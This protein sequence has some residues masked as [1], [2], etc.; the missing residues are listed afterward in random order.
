ALEARLVMR[1]PRLQG[2]PE[3]VDERLD[4]N[5]GIDRTISRPVSR[6]IEHASMGCKELHDRVE[7]FRFLRCARGD[8]K[9]LSEGST[10]SKREQR[11]DFERARHFVPQLVPGEIDRL[12]FFAG[13]E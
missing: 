9:L 1:S 5:R 13:L 6:E 8:T 3:V 2:F 11:C 10:N 7:V 4:W 12:H